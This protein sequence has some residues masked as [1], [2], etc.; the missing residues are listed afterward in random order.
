MTA[1][2][3]KATTPQLQHI[4]NVLKWRET[5]RSKLNETNE[6]GTL[7]VHQVLGQDVIADLI[8]QDVALIPP[9]ST[10]SLPRVRR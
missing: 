6:D 9:A 3:P 5:K 10:P 1:G 2:T 8:L 7:H 4:E